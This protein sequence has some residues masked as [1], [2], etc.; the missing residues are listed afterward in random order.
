M[1]RIKVKRQTQHCLPLGLSTLLWS[2]QSLHAPRYL[3][4]TQACRLVISSGRCG[5]PGD[6]PTVRTSH[7]QTLWSMSGLS[8]VLNTFGIRN[9]ILLSSGKFGRCILN[10]IISFQQQLN[11]I[12]VHLSCSCWVWWSQQRAL[13]THIFENLLFAGHFNQNYGYHFEG[14][15][16]KK[17]VCVCGRFHADNELRSYS[18]SLSIFFERAAAPLPSGSYTTLSA[19]SSMAVECIAHF[20]LLELFSVFFSLKFVLLLLFKN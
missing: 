16:L 19:C 14:V 9:R 10:R 5:S 3:I 18:C 8:S 11:T 17:S 15:S 6:A 1:Q 7:I 20:V 12:L 2:C 13:V 4:S